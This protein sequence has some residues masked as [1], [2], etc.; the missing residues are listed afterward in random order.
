LVLP[1]VAEYDTAAEKLFR[2]T[3]ETKVY[4]MPYTFNGKTITEYYRTKEV[5]LK[6]IRVLRLRN[7]KSGYQH[8]I[9]NVPK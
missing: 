6:N 1:I 9:G 7:D 4:H 8:C 3:E 5:Y 2:N